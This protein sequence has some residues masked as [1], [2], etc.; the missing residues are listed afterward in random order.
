MERA[1]ESARWQVAKVLD[2]LDSRSLQGHGSHV[3]LKD[4]PFETCWAL[5]SMRRRLRLSA[6]QVTTHHAPYSL[7]REFTLFFVG[8]ATFWD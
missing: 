3:A 5:L 8:P 4:I 6:P 1:L 7:E 2:Q